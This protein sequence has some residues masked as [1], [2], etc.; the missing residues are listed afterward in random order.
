MFIFAEYTRLPWHINLWTKDGNVVF[1]YLVSRPN[2]AGVGAEYPSVMLQCQDE[3]GEWRNDTKVEGKLKFSPKTP[4]DLTV[5]FSW[6]GKFIVGVLYAFP[7]H[8]F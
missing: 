8:F 4:F 3:D 6:E 7:T 1:Q 5:T 2:A